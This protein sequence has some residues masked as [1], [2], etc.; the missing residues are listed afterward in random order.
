MAP[1]AII[2]GI[3]ALGAPVVNQGPHILWVCVGT[4][5]ALPHRAPRAE[6]VWQRS[7]GKG[8]GF[9]E[10]PAVISN[11]GGCTRLAAGMWVVGYFGDLKVAH[12][13]NVVVK[14]PGISGNMLLTEC[15]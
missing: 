2:L 13:R 7:K 1:G 6:I 3:P 11:R 12:Y 10:F 15:R 4:F 9:S 14:I 5:K 8:Q